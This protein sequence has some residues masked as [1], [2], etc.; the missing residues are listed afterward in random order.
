MVWMGLGAGI[1]SGVEAGV[2]GGVAKAWRRHWGGACRGEIVVLD[3]FLYGENS[4]SDVGW[5]G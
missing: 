3:V 2:V 5:R 4:R 1:E